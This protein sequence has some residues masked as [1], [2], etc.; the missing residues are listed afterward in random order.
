MARVAV[1][2]DAVSKAY[3]IYDHPRLRL[4]EAL[5][6]GRRLYHSDFWALRDVT[7]RVD[8]GTTLGIIG[9]NGSG[10]STLLQVVAGI[11]RPTQGRVA[12]QGRVASL[13]ELGAGFNPEFTGRENVLMHGAVLGYGREEMT[14]R[15]PAVEA[16]AEIGPFFDQPVKTYS[17]GMFVRLAFAGAIHVDPDVLL[18]DEALAVGDAVFQHRCIRRIREFQETGRTILF[19]SHDLA[20]VKAVCSRAVF[21]DAGRVQAD[22]TPGEIAQLYHAHVAGLEARRREPA[23]PPSLAAAAGR[24]AVFRVD[25]AFDQRVGL[26]RHGTGTARIRN[27][28]ALDEAG[29]PIA[30]A[31]FDQPVTLRVHL[32][33]HAEAP[34]SILGYYLRDKSGID[35]VGTNT[36]DEGVPMPAR[37]AGDT[38]VVDFR[39]RWP[40]MAGSYSVTVA[41]AYNR[42]TPAYFDW[43]DNALVMDVL[44]PPGGKVIHAKVWLPVEIEVYG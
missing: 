37:R 39:Q 29:H 43:I 18:V 28:E 33:F 6:R 20:M 40:L 14:A 8:R 27:V 1:E 26:F 21:L 41:L 34:T 30:A 36:Y 13:L 42:D 15:L 12:V 35:M 5:T 9:M 31:E 19:V 4:L 32:E 3:R 38:L 7:L 23:A 24:P 17:S 25:P 16:F 11:V 10:K 2:L 22:G 44:P